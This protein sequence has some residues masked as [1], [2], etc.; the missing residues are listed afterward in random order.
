MIL[1]TRE[2]NKMI[3]KYAARAKK[4]MFQNMLFIDPKYSMFLQGCIKLL[5][6]HI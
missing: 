1:T 2:E 5:M 4:I 3:K 6:A